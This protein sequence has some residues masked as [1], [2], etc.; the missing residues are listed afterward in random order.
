MRISFKT[1][2]KLNN[3]QR[4]QLAKHAGV[5]RHAWNWGLDLCRKILD[6]N[7]ENPSPEKKLKF[8]SSIDLH[9]FLV[10]W[11]KSE[12]QWYYEVSKTTPQYALRQLS[13][14]FSDFFKKKKIQGKP[15][16]FPRFKKKGQHDSFTLEGTIKIKNKK[17]QLPRLGELKTYERLPTGINPKTVVIS[18][19]ADR[20]FIAF[21]YEIE[22]TI[23]NKSVPVCGVDLGIANLATLSTKEVFSNPQPYRQ[24]LRRLARLQ[25]AAS[26][27]IKG[28]NNRRK[29]NIKVAKQLAKTANIRK[30]TLDKLT[31]YLAKNHGR[32]VIEDLNVR[33]LMANH[34]LA[35]SIADS[36][37]YEFRCQLTYKCELY[38][39]EL[40]VA[41]RFFPSSKTCSACGYIQD[42]P[43]SE[44]VFNCSACHSSIGR[45]LNAALNLERL[46]AN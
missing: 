42:M 2:L 30:D 26:R 31:S 7:R 46:V 33:G 8:P 37:F 41:D 12:H 22:P 9:K 38:G 35:L 14:A 18:R 40:I 3:Y 15:V 21:N 10:K 39:S 16:G 34:R 44:R 28:S 45:D 25:R 6:Y 17:I 27:K 36:G 24:S 23:T 13:S 20:W 43:L 4:T 5:A 11:V 1:E 19:T 29:A 32:I